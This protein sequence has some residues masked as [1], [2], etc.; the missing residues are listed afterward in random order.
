MSVDGVSIGLVR[1]AELVQ[2]L[3]LLRA[4]GAYLAEI[5]N[6]PGNMDAPREPVQRTLPLPLD[7]HVQFVVAVGNVRHVK[8]AS[9]VEDAVVRRR[10]RDHYGA[11]LRM[12]VAKNIRDTLAR[13][14]HVARRSGLIQPEVETPSIEERKYVVKKRIGIWK[15]DA[16]A[17]RHNQQVWREH[18]V[19]LQQGR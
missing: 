12:N 13:K 14:D 6:G 11:H 2:M 17:H 8:H 4:I 16:A 3:W 9:W 5:G 15:C 1:P 10:Q 7:P 18:L 19:F